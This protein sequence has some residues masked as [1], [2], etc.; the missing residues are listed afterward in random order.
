MRQQLFLM[1]GL[2]VLLFHFCFVASAQSSNVEWLAAKEYTLYWGDEVNHS[3]YYIKAE[4]F[5]PAKPTDVN[6]DYVMLSITSIYHDSWGAILGVN[7]TQISNNTAFD[8]RLNITAIEVVT[9]NDIESPYAV[10]DVAIANTTTSP[11]PTVVPWIDA[12]LKVEEDYSSEVYIDER[13]YFSL[14]ITNKQ[15]VPLEDV[16]IKANIPDGLVMDPDSDSTW[17][18]SFQPYQSKILEY[19]LK[20][21]RPGTYELNG[22]VVSV[23]YEGRH[24][25]Q[26]LNATTLVI[27]GPL[28]NVTKSVNP[29][30][31]NLHDDVDLIINV[32]NQG[33]RAAYITVSDQLPA[34][35][36]IVSGVTGG[37][38]VLHPE[39]NFSLNYTVRMDKAGDIVIPS[40]KV[41]FVDSKDYSGNAYSK[42]FI[43]QVLDP[44]ADVSS[45]AGTENTDVNTT[46]NEETA[47]SNESSQQ[48][49]NTTE[50]VVDHGKL[51]FLY[52]IL[53]MVTGFFKKN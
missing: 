40:A 16:T 19:S 1:I 34:G 3:G 44:D 14:T 13:A 32:L 43:L 53:D 41:K 10:I 11:L 2:T 25:F 48:S 30:S 36:N 46:Y 47:F 20:G 37:S 21:L 29:N 24:Y 52:D 22:T 4:D 18:Y 6:T 49:Q 27:H 51:Q 26:E 23:N 33:D 50:P 8:D 9:G 45:S 5:S 39:D 31:V 35:G 15:A 28:I 7:N 38:M 12:S 42:K 17:N